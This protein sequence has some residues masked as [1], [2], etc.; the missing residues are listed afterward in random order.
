MAKD[1]EEKEGK[2]EKKDEGK[3]RKGGV[4][5]WVVMGVV[6][7]A[8]LGIGG[9]FAWS[10]FM[11]GGAEHGEARAEGSEHEGKGK[12]ARGAAAVGEMFEF[13]PFI[14]NLAD[15]PG[16]RY[17]KLALQAEVPSP[18]V[19]EELSRRVPQVRDSIIILLTSKRYEAISTP[20]GKSQLRSEIL[21]R[22]NQI[23]TSGQVKGVYFTEFVVQ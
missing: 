2:E 5:K 6:A 23:L 21:A 9:W 14:V 22:I 19:K 20:L 15:E 8:A 1:P 13:Q 17:L 18:E 7:A 3:A 11:G 4:V 10:S 12:S 16:T